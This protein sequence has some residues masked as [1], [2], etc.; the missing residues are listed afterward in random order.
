ML[1][2][3]PIEEEHFSRWID[4]RMAAAGRP[5]PGLGRRCLEV[6]GPRTRDVVQL[7]RAC[8]R[9]W[10]ADV[11]VDPLVGVGFLDIVAEEEGMA[12][13]LWSGF[14][15]VQQD[16]LR[17]VAGGTS[18]LT[19]RETLDRF[20][21]P[22]SGTVSNTAA[23][24]VAGDVLVKVDGPPGYDFESPFFRGWVITRALADVGLERAPTWRSTLGR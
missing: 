6:A 7:A 1:L 22:A 23:A 8:W 5:E 21:L 15:A 2:L 14:T 18:A 20:A 11:E 3:G 13:T 24:L 17:A 16:V 19:T 10:S 12:R 4:E 9:A